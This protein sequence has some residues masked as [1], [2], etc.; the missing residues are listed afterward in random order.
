MEE[1]ES[2]SHLPSITSYVLSIS[3]GYGVQATGSGNQ[4]YFPVPSTVEPPFHFSPIHS[5]EWTL[6]F[7]SEG[8]PFLAL[9][10]MNLKSSSIS[11]KSTIRFWIILD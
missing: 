10:N 4:G 2:C 8:S 9:F 5:H 11:L 7:S 3:D 6:Y 1:V